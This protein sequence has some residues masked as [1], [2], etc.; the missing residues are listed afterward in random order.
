MP[1]QQ[2]MYSL[3]K[4][5]KEADVKADDLVAALKKHGLNLSVHLAHVVIADMHDVAKERRLK[6]LAEASLPTAADV[7]GILKQP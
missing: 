1:Y 3:A 6:A 7:C 2:L 5:K 4:Q